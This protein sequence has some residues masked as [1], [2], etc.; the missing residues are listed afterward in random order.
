MDGFQRV[1]SDP[2]AGEDFSPVSRKATGAALTHR[3][4]AVAELPLVQISVLVAIISCKT[5]E[6]RSG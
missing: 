1:P 5:P 6:R 2:T 4:E 3:R